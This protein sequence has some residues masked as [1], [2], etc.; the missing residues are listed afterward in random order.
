[1][2]E[3]E[4]GEH[5]GAGEQQHDGTCSGGRESLEPRE[6]LKDRESLHSRQDSDLGERP[7]QV[8]A[9]GSE[10]GL[11]HFRA[12]IMGGSKLVWDLEWRTYDR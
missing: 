2:H 9:V 8:M 5:C 3:T 12:T 6:C 11:A 10:E 4:P 1:M 7:E